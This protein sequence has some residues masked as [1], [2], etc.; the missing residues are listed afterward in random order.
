MTTARNKKIVQLRH[1][2][3]TYQQISGILTSNAM[4]S[5][6]ADA[7]KGSLSDSEVRKR[8]DEEEGNRISPDAVRKV[9][10]RDSK[11]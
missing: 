9:C 11:K 2:G 5:I 6:F 4:A 1:E 8:I 7:K 3:K 10:E